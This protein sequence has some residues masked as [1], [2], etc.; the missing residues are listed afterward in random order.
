MATLLIA[1]TTVFTATSK[2]QHV[3]YNYIMYEEKTMREF[4]PSII[5]FQ[6]QGTP[7]PPKRRENIIFQGQRIY[8]KYF[9]YKHYQ[10]RD[11]KPNLVVNENVLM[12]L[13]FSLSFQFASKN[14]H[15]IAAVIGVEFWISKFKIYN[16]LEYLKVNT[17]CLTCLMKTHHIINAILEIEVLKKF[18]IYWKKNQGKKNLGVAPIHMIHTQE[19]IL[20]HTSKDIALLRPFVYKEEG[21]L[22]HPLW[23]PQRGLGFR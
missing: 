13:R 3:R 18:Q 15:Y 19:A 12:I 8:Q 5:P 16:G 7:L 11:I 1:N 17:K 14:I 22:T 2:N 21:T 23:T 6:K 10:I 9:F 4:L 20:L